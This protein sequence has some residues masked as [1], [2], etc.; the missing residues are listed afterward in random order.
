MHASSIVRDGR[1]GICRLIFLYHQNFI[2]LYHNMA[3]ILMDRC[4][5]EVCLESPGQ[6]DVV[7]LIQTTARLDSLPEDEA[8]LRDVDGPLITRAIGCNGSREENFV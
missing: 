3:S 6:P 5:H 7:D 1:D 2:Q 8:T 4:I